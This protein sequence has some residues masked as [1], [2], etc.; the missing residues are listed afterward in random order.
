MNRKVSKD[1]PLMEITLRKFDK[2]H[3]SDSRELLRRFCIS[4]GLLQ[5]GDSRDIIVD[6]LKIMLENGKQNKFLTSN[7]I[8]VLV[9][10]EREKINDLRG[11]A[12]SNVR[13]HL[14]RLKEL[15]IIE[16]I[17]EKYRIK[18]FLPL[19]EILKECIMPILLNPTLDR[20][21]EYA[22]KIDAL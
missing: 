11:V 21:K 12:Y 19:S 17:N 4:I 8:N 7:E 9:I 2:P 10:K 1:I 20:I 3:S 14:K 16:D 5:P 22:E 18:E 15:K 13:R 6:L